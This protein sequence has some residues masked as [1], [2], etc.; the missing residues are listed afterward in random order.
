MRWWGRIDQLGYRRQLTDPW[1]SQR[2][3]VRLS[4]QKTGNALHAL[5]DPK[6]VISPHQYSWPINILPSTAAFGKDLPAKPTEKQL[7]GLKC[8]LDKAFISLWINKQHLLSLMQLHTCLCWLGDQIYYAHNLLFERTEHLYGCY[9]IIMEIKAYQYKTSMWMWMLFTKDTLA[10]VFVFYD[11]FSFTT[12][13]LYIQ[14]WLRWAMSIYCGNIT[15]WYNLCSFTRKWAV[16]Y[17]ASL[18]QAATTLLETLLWHLLLVCE[19][20]TQEGIMFW[21]EMQNVSYVISCFHML[22]FFC[23]INCFGKA[24]H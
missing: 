17:T 11:H 19:C 10:V 18:V 21:S 3:G 23:N 16:H 5:K 24:M 15:L 8:R 9:C 22:L 4:L 6:W 2:C 14:T 12:C 20:K 1:Q 13:F 7:M